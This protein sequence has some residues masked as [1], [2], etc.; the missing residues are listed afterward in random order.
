[1]QSVPTPRGINLW[2]GKVRAQAPQYAAR[3]AWPKR[4]KTAL[5]FCVAI[6]GKAEGEIHLW[7]Y[8]AT[9]A[10]ICGSGH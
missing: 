9:A 7:H 10:E 1:M 8:G 4:A 2:Q 3:H 6:A 5:R